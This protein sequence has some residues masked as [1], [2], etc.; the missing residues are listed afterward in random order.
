MCLWLI[1]GPASGGLDPFCEKWS[2]SL[3]AADGHP[4]GRAYAAAPPSGCP[5]SDGQRLLTKSNLSISSWMFSGRAQTVPPSTAAQTVPPS[6]AGSRL[7][8]S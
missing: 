3:P 8:E 1:L 6:T 5:A 7:S 2:G 4:G